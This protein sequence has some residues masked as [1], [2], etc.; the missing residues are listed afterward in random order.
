MKLLTDAHAKI[1]HGKHCYESIK[2]N[3]DKTTFTV[4]KPCPFRKFNNFLKLY[5]CEYMNRFGIPNDISESHWEDLVEHFGSES[6]LYEIA[7]LDLLFDSIKQCGVND[8]IGADE[9]F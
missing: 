8:G 1:P 4:T 6:E 2:M 5:Y 9:F 7:T 3:S